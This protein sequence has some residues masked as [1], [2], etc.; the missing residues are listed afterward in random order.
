MIA[1]RIRK[2]RKNDGE[3][4]RKYYNR[5]GFFAIFVQAMV[6]AD[7]KFSFVS[8][9]HAGSTHD[10]TEF[11]GTALNST[12]VGCHL[13]AWACAVAD[14]SYENE[15]NV[16]TPFSVRNLTKAEDGFNFYHSSCRIFVEQ[17]FGILQ[18]SQVG[19]RWGI[20]WSFIRT[21]VQRAT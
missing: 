21:S 2:P 4:A 16:L 13:S 14:D 19:N 20:L 7:Y 9:N 10:S 6:S 15:G 11:Q 8:A 18:V 3:E 5:N 17:S 1:L 12:V